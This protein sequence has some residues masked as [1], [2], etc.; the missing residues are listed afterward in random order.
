MS[1]TREGG[2][3]QDM[4]V[5][6]NDDFL[7]V[8]DP[9][10]P[11]A[12]GALEIIIK[13]YDVSIY[14]RIYTVY[15]QI[16]DHWTSTR[17]R[18]KPLALGQYFIERIDYKANTAT[19]QIIPYPETGFGSVLRQ[20]QV[21][22]NLLFPKFVW[23]KQSTLGPILPLRLALGANKL[24]DP[25]DEPAGRDP[26]CNTERLNAQEIQE[27]DSVRLLYNFKPLTKN[28]FLLVSK[29]HSSD[30]TEEAFVEAMTIA[31]K[32]NELYAKKGFSVGYIT[33]ADRPVAGQTVPHAHMHVTNAKGYL[34]ELLG[35]AKVVR[36]ICID[37]WAQFLVPSLF[38]LSD[39][40]LKPIIAEQRATLQ[41]IS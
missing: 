31:H 12:S 2:I 34:Q 26:F 39:K 11:L 28:D 23:T 21:T 41:E 22:W 19:C 13:K 8:R 7:C 4:A 32:I 27:Y 5:Y 35:I 25:A 36:K 29:K 30:F 33:F 10:V 24:P 38:R 9:V 18:G 1:T 16:Q 14:S 6:L 40:Q 15:R 37:S 20:I 3:V 17:L